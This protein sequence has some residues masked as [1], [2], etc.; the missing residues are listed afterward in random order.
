MPNPIAFLAAIRSKDNDSG[1]VATHPAVPTR[2][3]DNFKPQ[4]NSVCKR[5]AGLTLL[6]LLIPISQTH[7]AKRD[8]GAENRISAKL[9]AMVREISSERDKLKS[10][11][12]QLKAENEQ[13]KSALSAE[14]Q[15]AESASSAQAKLTAE[16]HA[17]Q[18]GHDHLQTQFDSTRSKLQE[19]NAQYKQLQ[20]EKNGL[21]KQWTSLQQTQSFTATELENCQNKNLE[22]LKTGRSMM[23][24]FNNRGVLDNLLGKEPLLGFNAVEIENLMQEYQD[25][26]AASKYQK[27]AESDVAQPV[28]TESTV[29]TSNQPESNDLDVQPEAE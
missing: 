24:N 8:E 14:K 18:S 16:L 12:T 9:Q 17:A 20:Q 1:L 21:Q 26:L 10:E 11:N 3:F 6:L 23:D 2:S 28:V 4:K 5:L 27:N 19:V 29:E 15:T 22:L 25:K 13:L 7:A